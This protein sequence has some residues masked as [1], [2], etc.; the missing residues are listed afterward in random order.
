[1]TGQEISDVKS[2]SIQKK[3]RLFLERVVVPAFTRRWF[4]FQYLMDPLKGEFS[5]SWSLW[6]ATLHDIQACLYWLKQGLVLKLGQHLSP[7]VS[8]TYAGCESG[9]C[10]PMNRETETESVIRQRDSRR[11]QIQFPDAY[12]NV[13]SIKSCWAGKESSGTNL[14]RYRLGDSRK[15]SK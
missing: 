1:M 7:S 5:F 14:R 15:C 3:K 6:P 4:A 12:A 11:C 13:L 9:N 10:L 2:D 8:E